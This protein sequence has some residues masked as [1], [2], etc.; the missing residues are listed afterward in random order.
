MP[1]PGFTISQVRQ[2]AYVSRHSS[3]DQ[4][5]CSQLHLRVALMQSMYW[6]TFLLL[7][8][9]LGAAELCLAEGLL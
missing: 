9:A 1:H 6:A 8:A 3:P 4:T 5:A 2:Q 7:Q